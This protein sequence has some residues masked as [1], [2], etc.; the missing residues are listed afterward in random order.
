M[1][2]WIRLENMSD[3]FSVKDAGI[4]INIAVPKSG[5][6]KH[7]KTPKSIT[8]ANLAREISVGLTFLNVSG[9]M[10]DVWLEGCSLVL[11]A[12]KSVRS[13]CI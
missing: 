7:K 1:Q 2:A 8:P 13:K 9:N 6:T 3:C 5:S 10:A 4:N 11:S 12:T